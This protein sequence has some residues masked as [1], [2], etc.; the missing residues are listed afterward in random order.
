MVGK[1]A[2]VKVLMDAERFMWSVNVQEFKRQTS[3]ERR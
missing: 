3:G 2:G 1:D